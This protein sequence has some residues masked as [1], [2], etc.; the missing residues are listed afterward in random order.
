MSTKRILFIC[1]FTSC[2]FFGQLSAQNMR[3]NSFGGGGGGATDSLQ[4]RDKAEDSI[5]IYYRLYNSLAIRNMDTTVN[6][7]FSKFILPYSNY[8][9]GNLGNASKSYLFNPL[10]RGGWDAGFRSYEVYNYTLEQTPFYQTTKPYTEL[11]Y[12]LGG[13]GEQLIELLHTQNKTK[14]FNYSFAYRFSNAPGNLKNQHANLNNMRITANY[15]SKRKRYASY[16]VM[17]LNKSASSEN[18]GLVNSNLIDSLS[19]NNPYELETR[20]GISGVSFRNPF[21]TSIATG[22][23]YKEQNFV[24]KQ[25][26]D[27]GQKDSIVKDTVTTYLFYPRLR[28]QNEIKYQSNQFAFADANPL[29][30]NYDQYFNYKLPVG[31]TML[32]KDQWKRFTNEFSLVSFP[33]KTNPNQ[34]LQVGL[35]YQQLNFKD[36]LLSWSNHDIYGLGV[37]K[38]KTKNLRWD[39]Q[40]SGKLFLNGYHAGDYEA[41]FSLTSVFNKKGDQVALWLQNSNRTPS[42]NRLG[43]TAF[44]ISKLSTI[45]K[46]NIIEL[47]AMWD[48]KS[49]GLT[50]SFQY[51]LIQNFQYFGSGYQPLVYDKALSYIKGTV[52]NQLKLSTHWNWY[53]ELSLQLVD[54]NA[55]L[56]LPVIFTRQRLAFEGNFF[57]NL[58]LSTGLELIYHSA[59]QPDAYMP[60]TGQFYLQDQFTT[61]NRPIANAF[62]NFRIKRFKGF[63]RMEQLNTLLATSNQLGTRYQFTAPN[64][65]GTGTWLRVGI[66]WNFI[67]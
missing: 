38:N 34:F 22:T 44:P 64:Y 4:K 39:I 56:H 52:S 47:G 9:L 14:Q 2:L 54:P 63:I 62:L 10:Q 5:A 16:W 29:A 45:D 46:E 50:A 65:L 59:F 33:E 32:F 6:D 15:Q 49:R 17:L 58:F 66:W 31:Q 12:L 27:I 1:S 37:Y 26:Y 11:G 41:L 48:Q 35:G 43:I 36:T 42:F 18:G 20:L 19:L 8:H 53:N 28:F 61:N 23:T 24:W 13:K 57:K 51:K 55:P 60:L 67:N 25:T 3:F 30:L 7:F 40:A 21:N